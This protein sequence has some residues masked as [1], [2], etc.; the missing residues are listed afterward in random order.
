WNRNQI[1]PISTRQHPPRQIPLRR[2]GQTTMR[3]LRSGLAAAAF[4]LC[5]TASVLAQE[6]KRP[7]TF[8]DMIQL[9]RVGDPRISSDGKWV[10]YAV[11]TPDMTANRNAGNLW[12]VS[13][14]A[15]TPMQLTQS[16]HDSSP[17]W[18]PDAKQL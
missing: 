16:G 18:S 11:A 8:D 14:S 7:I 9:H 15:G 4:F 13:P 12:V 17:E 5:S 1:V 10:A 2:K 6:A 3:T